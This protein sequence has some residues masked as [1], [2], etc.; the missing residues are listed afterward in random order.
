MTTNR[1]MRLL[2]PWL[3]VATAIC[4][5]IAAAWWIDT[6]RTITTTSVPTPAPQTAP[7]E[8]R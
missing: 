7:Q 6:T 3:V 2:V 5:V 4:T 8:P 1:V